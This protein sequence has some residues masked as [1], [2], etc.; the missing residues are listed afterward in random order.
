[1][2]H[3]ICSLNLCKTLSRWTLRI[4]QINSQYFQHIASNKK[5][6]L[7]LVSK[8]RPKPT[9]SKH[10][11]THKK[12]IKNNLLLMCTPKS[13]YEH[14]MQYDCTVLGIHGTVMNNF[15]S[16]LFANPSLVL[17]GYMYST[18]AVDC[19]F[20]SSTMWQNKSQ[21]LAKASLNYWY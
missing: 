18:S 10:T 6:S 13:Y 1:M 12:A 9:Q 11:H 19:F 17:F 16:N 2:H 20:F 5:Q 7:I 4:N 14:R 15:Q 3:K 8:I 21:I